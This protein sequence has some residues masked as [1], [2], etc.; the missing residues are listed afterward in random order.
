MVQHN[1]GYELIG[2]SSHGTKLAI[3]RG[4]VFPCP[5]AGTANSITVVLYTASATIS[6]AVKC[7][8]YLHSDLSL[9]GV[10]EQKTVTVTSTKT[11]FTFN[12]ADP[13]PSLLATD[14][15]LVA[16]TDVSTVNNYM[17]YVTGDADQA[18]YQIIAYNGFPDPLA[19][20]H[21]TFKYSIYCTY[22]VAGGGG[23]S[24]P[25]AMH[26]YSQTRRTRIA[27]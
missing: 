23:I 3:I 8:I 20:S 5:E 15:V 17:G 16:F 24:V 14:Y 21:N 7:A 12:F 10:T 1:F 18:H 22:T 2:T 25:V 19:P 11:W 26:H 27:D 6:L 13:K 9:K 4:S